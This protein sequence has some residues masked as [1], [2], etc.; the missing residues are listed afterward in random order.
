[1]SL[2]VCMRPD[3]NNIEIQTSNDIYRLT[4]LKHQLLEAKKLYKTS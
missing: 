4:E 2:F 3:C 1:M